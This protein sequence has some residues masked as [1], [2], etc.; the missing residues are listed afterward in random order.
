[1]KK[2]I[3]LLAIFGCLL[4]CGC[5][6][7]ADIEYGI[8]ADNTAYTRIN[9]NVNAGDESALG[10]NSLT[11][12]LRLL[13]TH[14]RTRRGFTSEYDFF[15]ENENDAY[16]TLTKS[17]PA[18]SFEEAFENLKGMLCDE[19]LSVFSEV[20]CELSDTE[21][22]YAYRIKGRADLHRVIEN[23]YNSG[24]SRATADYTADLLETCSFSVTVSMPE[25]TKVYLL[26]TTEPTEISHEGRLFC[27]RGNYWG[28][29]MLEVTGLYFKI[30]LFGF[31]IFTL[32]C[33]IGM[34]IGFNLIKKGKKKENTPNG[35]ILNDQEQDKNTL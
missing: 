33:L 21:P 8:D 7:T 20:I 29:A 24:I 31:G 19:S 22:R 9:I 17:V 10:K 28:P 13:E 5:A 32:L 30:A 11:G 15:T 34:I 26:S 1:M 16:L 2:I 18:D 3:F 14:Y 23:T 25:N 35:E 6:A 4:F 27:V 12:D